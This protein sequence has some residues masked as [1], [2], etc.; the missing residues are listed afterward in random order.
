MILLSNKSGH[1]AE[2]FIYMG[3]NPYPWPTLLERLDR[4]VSFFKMYLTKTI[5]F[6]CSVLNEKIETPTYH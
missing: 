1:R 5:Q 6:K 4:E 3:N 2:H